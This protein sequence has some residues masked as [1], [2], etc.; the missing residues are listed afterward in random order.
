L[1]CTSCCSRTWKPGSLKNVYMLL[2]I[3]ILNYLKAGL[4]LIMM[5]RASYLCLIL[6]RDYRH[7]RDKSS[8]AFGLFFLGLTLWSVRASISLFLVKPDTWNLILQ[9]ISY[10]FIAAGLELIYGELRGGKNA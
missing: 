2:I 9:T 3:E 4:I 5:I 8:R 1:Y 7:N 6:F 10:L